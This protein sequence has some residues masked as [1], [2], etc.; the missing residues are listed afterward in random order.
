MAT[1]LTAPPKDSR[2]LATGEYYFETDNFEKYLWFLNRYFGPPANGEYQLVFTGWYYTGWLFRRTVYTVYL[3]L[4]PPPKP[5][6]EIS[7]GPIT[8]RPLPK[9]EMSIGPITSRLQGG[10]QC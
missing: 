2:L 6:L 10:K 1:S 4:A 5:T 3:R 8:T 9:L 7:I